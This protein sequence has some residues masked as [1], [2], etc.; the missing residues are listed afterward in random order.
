[1]WFGWLPSQGGGA[2]VEHMSDRQHLPDDLAHLP[3]GPVLAAALATIDVSRCT[4]ADLYIVCG[5]QARQVAH[6]QARLLAAMLET[7]YAVY[8]GDDE[9]L[10][11]QRELGEFSGD[12]LAFSLT[13]SRGGVQGHLLTAQALIEHLPMVYE[14]LLAGRIDLVRARAFAD[15]L[16]GLDRDSARAIATRLIGKAETWTAPIL[17]ERLRYHVLRADPSLAKKR[18]EQTV[19]DR[20][21]YCGPSLEGTASLGGYHLPPDRAAAAYN[22]LDRLARAARADGDTRNLAQLRADAMLDLLSGLPFR[23]H[24]KTDP[25]T[26]AADHAANGDTPPDRTKPSRRDPAPTSSSVRAETDDHGRRC[27]CG[28]V[29]P[30]PRRGVVDIQVE[31]STLMCLNDN[32]GLV[33]GFGPVIADIARQVAHDQE[34]NPMWRWSVT[35]RNGNLLHHGH[36]R[37]RP[38]AT[39]KAYVKARDKTCRAPGCRRPALNCDDDHRQ[40]YARHGPSHRGNLCVL[41]KHH[42]RLRHELGFVVHQISAQTVLWEAPNKL[43]YT[44]LPDATLILHEHYPDGPGPPAD[45]ER[46]EDLEDA[47][48]RP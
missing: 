21:V 39:E 27:V 37:R 2:S 40:E 1:M 14:A 47:F 43:L 42:H 3:A 46:D 16:A 28:G 24:P 5:A 36:T 29:Q 35:D 30:A 18:Y 6:E 13:W 26:M 34:A 25:I 41:C 32:P 20:G 22:R 11:R 9:S 48:G 8:D 23:L 10:S 45:F 44:V 17:R 38:N 12:Q 33:S 19:A 15:G 4:S 31:L 7:A